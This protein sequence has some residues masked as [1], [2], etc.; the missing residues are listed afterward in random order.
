MLLSRDTG[1]SSGALKPDLPKKMQSSWN[2]D[3]CE[4]MAVR[5]R[6]NYPIDSSSLFKPWIGY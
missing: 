4:T 3:L 2:P 5:G 6:N 1:E